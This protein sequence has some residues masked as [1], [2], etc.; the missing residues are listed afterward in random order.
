MALVIDV[1]E[2]FDS[3]DD[4]PCVGPDI[5]GLLDDASESAAKA[6]IPLGEQ[7]DSAGVAIERI[8][9]GELEFSGNGRDAV[10]VEKSLLDFASPRMTADAALAGVIAEGESAAVSAS[11]P[12][13]RGRGLQRHVFN[14]SCCRKIL[15]IWREIH[16]SRR[17]ADLPGWFADTAGEPSNQPISGSG[18]FLLVE[19]TA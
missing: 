19:G 11:G 5:G 14:S 10:P 2:D 6:V 12:G 4:G 17:W 7:A 16:G 3:T 8:T 15:Q 13:A 9:P 18:A 1:S